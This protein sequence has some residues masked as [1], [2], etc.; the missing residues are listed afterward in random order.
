MKRILFFLMFIVIVVSGYSQTTDLPEFSA[1]RPGMA[2]P[3][4]I[5][6][7]NYFQI[8]TGFAYEKIN[9]RDLF[10]ETTYYN[11]SVFR[12]G[13]NKNSEIRLQ[14]DYLRVKTDSLRTTGL[15]PLTIGTKLLIAEENKF[16]PQTSFLFNLA[17]PCFGEKSFRPENL[18]P[19][20]YL[21]MQND[22]TDK[23]NVCYNI[24]LEYDG[25]NAAPSVFAA[26]CLGYNFTEKFSIFIENYNWFA[27]TIRPENY[28]DYG[29]AYML[30]KN[31]QID[32]SGNSD[33]RNFQKYYMLNIGIAWRLPK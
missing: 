21:L 25:S 13:I 15:N 8:E 30:W 4:G 20:F 16:I 17:L 22:I 29:L 23:F 33:L 27:N 12:Y 6:P 24:G 28:V 2:T 31:F 18:A 7:A 26:V 5:M 9:T 32:I 19:S 1:D 10:Q 11:T 14:T 3:P